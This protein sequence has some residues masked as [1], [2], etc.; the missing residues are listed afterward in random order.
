MK[1]ARIPDELL[2]AGQAAPLERR[3]VATQATLDAF[4]GRVFSWTGG[5]TCLHLAHAH[6]KACGVKVPR[7][8]TV[9]S[10]LGAA[11]ALKARGWANMAEVL[12]GVGLERLPAPAMMTVG[13]LAFRSSEDGF[14]AVLVC[15]GHGQLLG[16]V[17]GVATSAGEEAEAVQTCEVFILTLD[18]VEAAW[19]VPMGRVPE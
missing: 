8:P 17:E 14:G 5:K 13:D 12:D 16:W 6:L 18:Q 11:K 9:R 10:P 3:R 7:L 1:G 15:V 19:S 2:A 4:R